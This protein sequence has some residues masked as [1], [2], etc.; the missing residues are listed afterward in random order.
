MKLNQFLEL[1]NPYPGNNFIEVSTHLSE[2]TI[3]LKNLLDQKDSTLDLVFYTQKECKLPDSFQESKIQT[4][5][6]FEKIFRVL[7]RSA[8]II[9]LKDIFHLHTNKNLLLKT[10]YHALAN[11]ADIIIM[12]KK[13]ILNKDEIYQLFEE[14]EF[15]ATNFIDIVDGY[16]LVMAKKMHMWGN[17]L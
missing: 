9:I 3:A 6:S 15:R 1:F 7:P 16:D 12:E 13:G 5:N 4:I 10:S 14:H 11:T 17:G 2:T 8:D